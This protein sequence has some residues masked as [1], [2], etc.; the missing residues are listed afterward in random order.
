MTS[1]HNSETIF[2]IESTYGD[3]SKRNGNYDQTLAF[4]HSST[5]PG[6]VAVVSFNQLKIL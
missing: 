1:E 4:P 6:A 5:T 2:S 3:G